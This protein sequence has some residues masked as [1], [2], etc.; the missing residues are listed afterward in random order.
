MSLRPVGR[1][2]VCSLFV[3]ACGGSASEP[4]RTTTTATVSVVDPVAGTT[5]A[6]GAPFRLSFNVEYAQDA[7]TL[8]AAAFVRDDGV[9]SPPIACGGGG[10][11]GGAFAGQPVEVAGVLGPLPSGG[12]VRTDSQRFGNLL[13]QF[14]RGRRV[15]AV[16]LLNECRPHPPGPLV[17]VHRS[18]QPCQGS[19][20]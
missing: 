5:L 14:A 4:T 17:D 7:F 1:L 8:Y 9:Y 16:L 3:A 18:E 12:G 19:P 6:I 10:S 11:S 20:M 13:Y 15:N 2:C